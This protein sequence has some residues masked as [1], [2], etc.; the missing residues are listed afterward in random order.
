MQARVVAFGSGY[1]SIASGYGGALTTHPG[2]STWNDTLTGRHTSK[3]QKEMLVPDT[4]NDVPSD[5][6]AEA[7]LQVQDAF[8]TMLDQEIN[9]I[10]KKAFAASFS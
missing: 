2:E 7:I 8:Y 5:F 10:V 4:W 3:A 6:I 1:N 9:G